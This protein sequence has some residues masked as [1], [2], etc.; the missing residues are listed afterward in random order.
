MTLM[1]DDHVDAGVLVS[2]VLRPNQRPGRSPEHQLVLDRYRTEAEFRA[3]ADAVLHGLGARVLSDGD[4]GLV[5]AVGARCG[6]ELMQVTGRGSG[7][8]VGSGAI[9]NPASSRSRRSARLQTT[10]VALPYPCEDLRDF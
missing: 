2:W 7:T 6:R 9:G 8:P 1:R 3:A 10:P 4:F 5:L